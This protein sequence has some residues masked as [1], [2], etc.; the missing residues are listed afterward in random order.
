MV[1]FEPEKLVVLVGWLRRRVWLV[2]S[3]SVVGWLVDWLAGWLVG[4]LVGWL[5]ACLFGC[6]V[7]CLLW[8]I[9][10]M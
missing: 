7:A 1:R 3:G 10:A 9:K 5:L 8:V 6:S 4:W 2:V